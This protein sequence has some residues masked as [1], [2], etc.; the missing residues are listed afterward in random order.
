GPGPAGQDTPGRCSLPPRPFDSFQGFGYLRQEIFVALGFRRLFRGRQKPFCLVDVL[1]RLIHER[2]VIHGHGVLPVLVVIQNDSNKT[3]RLDRLE[4][5][6]NVPNGK[7][8]EAT[9][10]KDVRYL[11][12]P[13]QPGVI[14]GPAGKVKVL[15]A[16]KNP[17]NSP[18]IE[19]RA[20]TAQML[21]AGQSA[22][23]FFYFQ[24]ALQPGATI[25]LNGLAEAGPEGKELFYFEIP[26]Q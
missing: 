18:D 10:A 19:A 16:R 22:S 5:Q 26:L 7:K 1:A 4:V 15:A 21:P 23:G 25:Y 17:L 24:T 20:M 2:Q 13:R 12:P 6:Y 3:I 9:P 11:Q 14:G 8:I